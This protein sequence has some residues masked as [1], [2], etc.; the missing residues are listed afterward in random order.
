MGMTQDDEQITKFFGEG[1]ESCVFNCVIR[2]Y[3]LSHN[4]YI[5]CNIIYID[6]CVYIKIV[7][8]KSK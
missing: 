4:R 2:K 6:V 8:N 7:Y 5:Q 3:L 1:S